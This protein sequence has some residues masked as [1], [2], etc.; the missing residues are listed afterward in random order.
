VSQQ[1][2]RHVHAPSLEQGG[3]AAKEVSLSSRVWGK[4]TKVAGRWTAVQVAQARVACAQRSLVTCDP[5][6]RMRRHCPP[7]CDP[8]NRVLNCRPVG[9][10]H[11]P[12]N[13]RPRS[14]AVPPK[15]RPRGP[16]SS[17]PETHPC[18]SCCLCGWKRREVWVNALCL[19][20]ATQE[21]SEHT[22]SFVGAPKL[23]A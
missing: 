10:S 16:E 22:K 6:Q 19:G 17:E 5:G 12:F 21:S 1:V 23:G 11:T 15:H 20:A 3:A 4:G 2:W 8:R 18:P 7:G 13:L 9:G 14:R